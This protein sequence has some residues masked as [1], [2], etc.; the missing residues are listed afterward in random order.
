MDRPSLRGAPRCSD[1]ECESECICFRNITLC[2][3]CGSVSTKTTWCARIS[4]E[5]SHRA[6]AT[7]AEDVDA[8]ASMRRAAII[9]HASPRDVAG[10]ERVMRTRTDGHGDDVKRARRSSP[11]AL[12]VAA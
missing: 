1:R 9:I 7:H 11:R 3:W 12:R 6:G 4:R 8:V 5:N 2:V 10:M